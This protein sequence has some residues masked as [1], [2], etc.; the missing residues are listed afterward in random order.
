MATHP[1][2]K[3]TMQ[4]VILLVLLAILLAL[5]A[6]YY[7]LTRPPQLSGDGADTEGYEFSIYGFEGDLLR[8]PTGVGIDG[9]GRIY[10]ADTGKKRI[11]VFDEA[12][13]F[14]T[15]FGQSGR[16]EFQLDNPLDVAVALDGRAYVVDKS[17]GK[18]VIYDSTLQPIDEIVF[19][20]PPLS[21]TIED[22]LL[23][24][25][26]QSGVVIGDLDGEFTTGYVAR[27]K[28][29]GQFDRPA[30]VAVGDDGTLYVADGLNYRVQ[31]ISTRGETLWTYGEPLPPDEAIRFSDESRKFGLPASITLDE[32]GRLYVV[33]GVNSEI[34]VLNTDGEFI[35]K[36]G[37]VGHDD[38]LFYFPDGIDYHDGRIAVA[39]KYN[40]R[41]Q[42]FAVAL[43]GG[44]AWSGYL[45]LALLFL[46]L[47]LLLLPLLMR[48]RG[49]YVVTPGFIGALS[50]DEAFGPRVAE[51]LKRVTATQELA[52]TAVGMP[53]LDEVDWK[54]GEPA[55]QEVDGL[56]QRFGLTSE[57][58]GALQLAAAMRGKRI[59][60]AEEGRVLES[61]REL[62]VPAMTYEEIKDVLAGE[63]AGEARG[64][65]V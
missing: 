42:V 55:R 62:E 41:V 2:S 48:R 61:A 3:V 45:P 22:E 59:L 46:A 38:G 33:D 11:V 49:R 21:V 53:G 54:T 19:P 50:Q 13:E 64:E 16:G 27:G 7:V 43:P 37:D 56:M 20:E 26:T 5:A 4:L 52:A 47:P 40:D 18:M 8:R 12:G 30:G 9:R 6:A 28:E 51:G 44:P 14:V 63:Q 17:L 1:R 24:V 65:D 29:P 25:T 57:E 23:F 32:N 15:V 60:L 10:V 35:E 34:A 58:A 36:I 39:D 31:A